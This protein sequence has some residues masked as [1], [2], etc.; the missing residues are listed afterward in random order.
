MAGRWPVWQWVAQQAFGKYGIDAEAALRNLP[1][2]LGAVGVIS[3]QAVRT[4]PAAPGNSSPGIEAR[5][6]L[7]V[8]GLFHERRDEGT[9]CFMHSG[10]PLR[11]RRSN[12]TGRS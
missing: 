10:R 4:V 9:L 1:R 12:R 11:S 2:W 8:H 5:I 7:T 3:Y 6:A